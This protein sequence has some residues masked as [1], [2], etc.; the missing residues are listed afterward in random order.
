[1]IITKEQVLS[2]YERLSFVKR[3]IQ[4]ELDTT[5]PGTDNRE[6]ALQT[7]NDAINEARGK[8]VQFSEAAGFDLFP[9]QNAQI[10]Q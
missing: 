4:D 6:A 5:I 1:M 10:R 9:K 3:E 7:L 2:W 8:V